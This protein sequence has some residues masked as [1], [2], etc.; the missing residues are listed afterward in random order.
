MVEHESI[1]TVHTHTH[2]HT[3]YSLQDNNLLNNV[4]FTNVIYA[5]TKYNNF[6]NYI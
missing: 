3:Q 5:T 4:S 1:G 6:M 2:T